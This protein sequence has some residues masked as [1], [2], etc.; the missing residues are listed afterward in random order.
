MFLNPLI[1]IGEEEAEVANTALD[2]NVQMLCMLTT[3]VYQVMYTDLTVH[4]ECMKD[5]LELLY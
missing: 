4:R 3:K 2:S 5:M 1:T